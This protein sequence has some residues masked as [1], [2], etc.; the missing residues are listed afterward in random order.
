M[1]T[2]KSKLQRAADNIR[3]LAASMVEKA[4]S[5]HP[6]GAMGGADFVNVLFA[7]YLRYDPDDMK[8]PFR[9]RFFLDPGH[10]SP[11]L[12]SVL[13]LAGN[14]TMEDL[15]SF[16][17]W[18]SITPGHPEVDVM[19]GV[20]NT[21][22]PLGQGHAMGVGAALAERFLAARFGEWLSHKTYIY[23]SDGAVQEE[24]SQGVGRIAGNL[25]L[26]NVIMY[27]DSNNIQLSTKVEEVDTEDVAAKY[28]AWN[29]NVIEICG[30]DIDQIRG[31][32][33]TAI[34]ET[35][36]PTIIIG[37]TVMGKGAVAADGSSFEDKVSTHGQPL[38]A[39]GADYA[40]T[41]KNLG[42]DP[43]NPFCIFSESAEVYGARREELRAIIAERKA[44]EQKWRSEDKDLARKLDLSFRAKFRR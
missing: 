22:G 39:A 14:Y 9:D 5:G 28:R 33:D 13:A 8:Y 10:M 32:L 27:Y 21:S 23:I 7:E 16:R 15:A 11:M 3:V 42:G 2:D 6:G 30:H 41:V 1:K 24:I 12:Y 20:E 17:Q 29:W 18:G 36:R 26:H 19:H 40:A 4:K 34:A 44:E 38:S 25:G 31:A 43:E 35:E 37:K